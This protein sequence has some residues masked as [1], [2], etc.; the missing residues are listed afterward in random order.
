MSDQTTQEFTST[1]SVIDD[2]E[3]VFTEENYKPLPDDW[4]IAVTDVVQSRQAIARGKYKSVN[5]AGVSMISAIMNSLGY[6]DVPYIFGG[7][8]AAAVFAPRDREV[9]EDA[10]SCMV[11]WVSKH[12]ELELRLAI[13]PVAAVRLLDSD[14]KVGAVRVSP[15]VV[16]YAF[17]GGGI[18][19]AEAEMKKGEFGIA[20]DTTGRIPDLTGLSCRWTPIGEVEKSVV[21]LIVEGPSSEIPLA[22]GVV[23][24]LFELLGNKERQINPMPKSGPGFTWPPAG[25]E[26]ESKLT[27]MKKRLLYPITILAW[28]LDKTGIKLGSFDPNRYRKFTALNTDYRKVQDGLRMTLSLSDDA[29]KG[30][31]DFLEEMRT[32]GKLRFG[33]CIQDEAVL[34]CFVPSLTSDSHFH[35]MDG[36]GG[37]YAAAASDLR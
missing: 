35:F 12:L 26:L 11:P 23:T 28:I 29:I 27:G 20:A 7:D 22:P 30:L 6:Q 5:M 16:N 37:G 19:L 3:Q 17:S 21:S 32:N 33:I 9:I 24:Q 4:L 25:L 14:V 13:V 15:A 8:G 1:L 2:F 18:S 31:R 10:L 36:S 34:T